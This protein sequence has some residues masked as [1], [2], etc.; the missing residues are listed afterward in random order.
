MKQKLFQ[1]TAGSGNKFSFVSR[2]SNQSCNKPGSRYTKLYSDF[3][4][5]AP[6]VQLSFSK[7]IGE[8]RQHIQIYADPL[9]CK[10][11]QITNRNSLISMQSL[12]AVSDTCTFIDTTLLA[13]NKPL[14]QQHLSI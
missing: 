8:C 14:F 5:S 2:L 3:G 1:E 6:F 12:D 4:G 7:P 13:F 10:C 9:D 11:H